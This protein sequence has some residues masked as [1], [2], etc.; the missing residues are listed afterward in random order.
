MTAD[1]A[2]H[3]PLLRLL[4]H[5][6]RH[7]GTFW[8][9][10]LSGLFV[11]LGLLTLG[12]LGA[13]TLSLAVR[14]ERAAVVP[15]TAGLLLTAVL[16]AL[17][18]WRESYVAHD[19]AYR[20]L[21]DLRD[22]VFTA[23]RRSLPAR[24][25]P[26]HSGDLGAVALSDVETL[27][28]LYAHTAAQALVSTVL[29]TVTIW[30]S[31]LLSPWLLLAWGP[32]LLVIAALPWLTGG[33]AARRGAEL[34]AANA[35]LQAD[36][37]ETVAGMREL[38]GAG[39]LDRRRTELAEGTRALTRA[40]RRIA[41]VNGAETA[42]A[43]LAVAAAGAAA[44]GMTAAG[45]AGSDPALAPVAFALATVALGP[46]AQIS[47]LLRN[48][49]TLLAAARRI[50]AVL[51]MPPATAEPVA[52]L[53]PAP[54]PLVFDR[55]TF[56][57][58]PT[59]PLVLDEVSFTARPGEIVALVGPSGGGK[60]TCVSL[61]LR[62]W[63]PDSGTITLGGVDLSRLADADL[64]AAVTAVPQRIDLLAGT[65]GDNVR[66]AVPD[67]SPERV[68][69]AASAAGLLAPASGLPLGLDTPVAERGTGLSGGQRARV[70]LARALLVDAPVLILDEAL[71]AL[72]AHAE[73]AL[74]AVLRERAADRITLVVTHRASTVRAAD[75]VLELR[76]GRLR[77]IGP[78]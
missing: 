77:P 74:H 13:L 20:I 72:D 11:Q 8:W 53:P 63:D 71:A 18:T 1:H 10:L 17:V 21:A 43:D 23:S 57:Y 3:A 49:G 69:A 36:I 25:R 4:P 58:H 16:C 68:H 64:R 33:A 59:G 32:A 39:A 41:A 42:V 28:W 7:R 61:A 37:V 70:A 5:V 31:L 35:A 26:R 48:F 30:L 38:A 15:L 55:V 60:S 19:L 51:T 50:D 6:T 14:G 24:H 54:G 2:A 34:T 75:R 47:A 73:A 67:A 56:R 65:V 46:I 40:Q 45:V 27:E 22:R 66:L 29:L 12:L 78:P 44:L 62:M 9:T 76:S 52:P